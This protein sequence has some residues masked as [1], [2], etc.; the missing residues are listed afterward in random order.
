MLGPKIKLPDAY[1]LIL[2]MDTQKAHRMPNATQ[3]SSSGNSE[4]PHF[5][6]LLGKNFRIYRCSAIT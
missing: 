3:A 4:V 2:K 6:D 5:E 1:G